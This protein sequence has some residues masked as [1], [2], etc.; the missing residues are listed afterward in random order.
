MGYTKVF[1]IVC[2]SLKMD[3]I[4]EDRIRE[5]VKEEIKKAERRKEEKEMIKDPSSYHKR[6]RE[7]K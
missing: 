2:I 1:K 7:I 4:Q 5:I 6:H 3:K